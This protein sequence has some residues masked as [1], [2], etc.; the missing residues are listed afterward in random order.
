MTPDQTIEAKEFLALLPLNSHTSLAMNH[1]SSNSFNLA[2][3]DF[4]LVGLPS[5]VE[6]AAASRPNNVFGTKKPWV[7]RLIFVQ[8]KYRGKLPESIG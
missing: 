3:P 5:Q 4:L 6:T 1:E 8:V 7:G 2:T